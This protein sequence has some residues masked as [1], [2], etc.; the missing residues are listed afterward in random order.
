MTDNLQKHDEEQMQKLV[1]LANKIDVDTVFDVGA[2]RGLVTD[3]MRIYFPNARYFLFEPQPSRSVD[4][5]RKYKNDCN[6]SVRELVLRD[7]VGQSEFYVGKFAPTSSIFD[8]NKSG[9]RYFD[10]EFV[11][12]KKIQVNSDCLDHFC[13]ANN[14]GHI[15]IL[16]LDTQGSEHA[17][18]LGGSELLKNQKIDIIF[19]EF[20]VVPHY[21]DA[22]LF[23]KIWSLLAKY[24]YG[25]YDLFTGPYAKNGQLRY[26]DAIFVSNKFRQE[27]L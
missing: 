17:I 6:I 25:L 10:S 1:A 5:V 24:E 13:A 16:K 7:T 3:A 18:L 23:D 15:N 22:P 14:I 20:F 11:M 8:R 4:L 12:E 21:E 27:K 26:G 2:Y 9:T 19:T